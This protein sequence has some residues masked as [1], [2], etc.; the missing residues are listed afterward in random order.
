MCYYCGACTLFSGLFSVIGYCFIAVELLALQKKK[1]EHRWKPALRCTSCGKRI[2]NI[3]KQKRY[4]NII[5]EKQNKEHEIG[6]LQIYNK[7][8]AYGN[9]VR[10]TRDLGIPDSEY[11]SVC[12]LRERLKTTAT[13]VRCRGRDY[14]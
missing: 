10:Y 12:T 9:I 6:S 5:I 1:T 2:A 8:S 14:R 3:C 7:L 11:G 4:N 13:T